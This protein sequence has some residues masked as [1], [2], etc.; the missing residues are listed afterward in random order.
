MKRCWIGAAVLAGVLLASIWVSS[1]TQAQSD[2]CIQDLDRAA[3]LAQEENWPR[4][5]ALVKRSKKR[6]EQ[7]RPL[8]AAL[9]SHE[10]MEQIDGLFAQAVTQSNLQDRNAFCAI[11][12][13]LTAGL[14]AM[15]MAHSFNWW[16]LL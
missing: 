4:A 16:N 12:A 6:W 13:E 14:W 15:A 3:E 2:L 9:A 8:M 11:C 7:H 10:P 5:E 1:W